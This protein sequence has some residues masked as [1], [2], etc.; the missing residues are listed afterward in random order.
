MH[1]RAP[2]ATT[3]PYCGTGCGLLVT[4]DGQEGISGIRGD[5]SHPANYGRLCGKGMALGETL[6]MDGRLLQPMVQGRPTSWSD[7]LRQVADGFRQVLAKHGPEAV[8]FYVSGQLLTEDYYVANKLLKGFMGSANIDSNSR[9]CMASAVVGHKRA[10]GADL[11]PCSYQDVE[12]ADLVVIVGSN[13]AWCH[14][15]L[16]QRLLAARRADPRKRLVVVDPRRTATAM[17][18]DLHLPI[19]GGTDLTLWL[20]LLSRLFKQGGT[21]GV[22]LRQQVMM[23]GHAQEVADSYA[24]DA[25]T[26]ARLTGLTA[27]AVEEFYQLFMAHRRT[28]TLFSQGIDQS[29]QGSDQVNA[30]LNVH[31][32]SGRLGQPGMGPFSITGQPNAMGGRE[33]GA[34]ANQLACHLDFATPGHGEMLARFW[35]SDVLP[36]KPGLQAVEMFQAM[37]QGKIKAVWIMG[38]NPLVSLPDVGLA[39]RALSRCPLVVVSEAVKNTD[40]TAMAHILLPAQPWGEKDGTVTNSEH[41]ISRQRPFLLPRG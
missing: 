17:E 13:T 20:G 11:V 2:V 27:E 14:P 37:E 38:T 26:V 16:F 5:P 23:E 6:A 4:P 18:A 10:F 30:I 36:D 1:S 21:D 32:A 40:T 34:L 7:A 22:F 19:Q 3:C 31:L 25:A 29:V 9:L 8:A 12:L 35:Q 39:R 15:I 28:V 41:C 33:V 24:P